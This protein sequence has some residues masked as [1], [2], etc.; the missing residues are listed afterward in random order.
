[1]DDKVIIGGCWMSEKHYRN[2]L[3]R[4]YELETRLRDVLESEVVKQ[5]PFAGYSE[6][7]ARAKDTLAV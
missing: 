5:A 1:M 4:I 6:A 3:A 2:L 7:I